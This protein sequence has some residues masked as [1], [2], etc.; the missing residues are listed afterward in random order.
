MWY[1]PD[2]PD[3]FLSTLHAIH[4]QRGYLIHASRAFTWRVTGAVVPE[5]IQWTPNAFNLVGFTVAAGAPPTFAQF[6]AGSP[7][8]QHN[9][10][11]RLEDGNWRRVSDPSGEAMREGEAFWIYCDGASSY[12]GPLR[13]QTL[14]RQQVV[15]TSGTA[16]LILR[17]ESSHPVVASVQ[18]VP[19][20]GPPVP[21][22]IVVQTITE[23]VPAVRRMAAPQPAGAWTQELPSIEA[24]E[25]RGF[26]CRPSA[27]Q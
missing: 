3:A 15:L 1:A 20:V 19:S 14:L 8:H 25:S 2:R 10:I 27:R 4:G 16:D 5:E 6:F 18:H 7:A 24:G 23:G 26:P 11:Y 21:L 9:R 12:Q 17:N 22:S 13:V